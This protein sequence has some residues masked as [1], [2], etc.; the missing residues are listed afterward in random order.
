MSRGSPTRCARSKPSWRPSGASRRGAIADELVR[1]SEDQIVVAR[2]D[3]HTP[4]RA[5][6]AGDR[7]PRRPDA[8]GGTTGGGIVALVGL[9]PDGTKA[10]VVVALTKARAASGISAADLARDAARALGGGTGKQADLAVG[11]G[12]NVGALDDALAIL[13]AAVRAAGG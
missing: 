9:G 5:E 2:R 3:G 13:D 6:G 12:P 1:A 8:R 7:D 11:G 10:G 4:R